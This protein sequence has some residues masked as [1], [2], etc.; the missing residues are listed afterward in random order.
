MESERPRLVVEARVAMRA[1]VFYQARE[2]M[3]DE[4]FLPYHCKT[5][6]RCRTSKDA[7]G[8]GNRS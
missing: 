6:A 2:A 1:E 8:L 4:A 3:L 5:G 7:Q